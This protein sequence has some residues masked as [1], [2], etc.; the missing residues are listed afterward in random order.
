[1]TIA[2]WLGIGLLGGLGATARFLA[3]AEVGARVASRLPPGVLMVRI[4]AGEASSTARF[5]DS[6]T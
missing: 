5:T 4:S 2:V 1:M 6:S 3:D